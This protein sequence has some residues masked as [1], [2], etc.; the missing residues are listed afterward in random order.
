MWHDG[1][2]HIFCKAAQWRKKDHG[3]SWDTF[4]MNENWSEYKS[5]RGSFD[6][7][8]PDVW[9]LSDEWTDTGGEG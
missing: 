2:S 6:V 4:G 3:I 1:L 5:Q 9:P 8:I 7:H